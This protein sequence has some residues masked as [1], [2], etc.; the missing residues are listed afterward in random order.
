MRWVEGRGLQ[1]RRD[2]ARSDSE[3]GEGA[4]SP[5]LGGFLRVSLRPTG[6]IGAR[7]GDRVAT[8][9]DGI[10]KECAQGLDEMMALPAPEE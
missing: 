8:L 9:H 3:A 5:N 1:T 6:S 7:Q 2:T 10:G 4:A